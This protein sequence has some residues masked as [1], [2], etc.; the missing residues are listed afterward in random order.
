MNQMGEFKNTRILLIK[1]YFTIIVFFTIFKVDIPLVFLQGKLCMCIVYK[2]N[3][4]LSWLLIRKC[5]CFC[6]YMCPE[7]PQKQKQKIKYNFF[8]TFSVELSCCL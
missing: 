1:T 7:N 2:N 4:N 5:S 3:L 6:T 8:L